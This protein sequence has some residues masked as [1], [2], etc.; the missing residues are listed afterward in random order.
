MSYI[1]TGD[2]LAQIKFA[3]DALQIVA[4]IIG[5]WIVYQVLLAA[6]RSK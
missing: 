6:S 3:V 5:A 4:V 2:Y 1:D